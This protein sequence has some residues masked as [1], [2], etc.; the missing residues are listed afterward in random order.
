MT[1]QSIVNKLDILHAEL[2]DFD[3]LAFMETWLST[4]VSTND[5][6]LQSYNIPERKDRTGDPHGEVIVY[7]KNGIFYSVGRN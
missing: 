1:V 4:A 3:I 5:L 7:V 6:M 2:L